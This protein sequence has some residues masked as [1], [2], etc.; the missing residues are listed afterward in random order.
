MFVKYSLEKLTIDPLRFLLKSLS[1]KGY[2]SATWFKCHQLLAHHVQFHQMY[3]H[4]SNE[5]SIPNLEKKFN[6]EICIIQLFFHLDMFEQMM[7]VNQLKGRVDHENGNT[8]KQTWSALADLF[9]S[10]DPDDGVDKV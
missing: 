2:A 7:Q 4:E 8:E 5:N 9:N 1:V 3:N 6:T 10:T